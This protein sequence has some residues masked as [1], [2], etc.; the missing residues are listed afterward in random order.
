MVYIIVLG[1]LL[2]LA[3]IIL[4][5]LVD[6]NSKMEREMERIIRANRYYAEYN[7]ELYES[8]KENDKC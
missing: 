1:G 2:I 7:E 3:L 8:A 5:K 4:G 6:A